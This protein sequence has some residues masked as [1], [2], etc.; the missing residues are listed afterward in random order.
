MR[1]L[2]FR[3]WCFKDKME[4]IEELLNKLI[5]VVEK[6]GTEYYAGSDEEAQRL[7]REQQIIKEQILNLF[8]ENN[9]TS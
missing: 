8:K 4:V 7:L 5:R 2:K 6:I 1:E 9:A 3:A